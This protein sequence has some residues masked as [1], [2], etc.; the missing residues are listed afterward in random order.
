MK[1]NKYLL[2][3]ITIAL[4]VFPVLLFAQEDTYPPGTIQMTPKVDLNL[5]SV[6][7]I[8]PEKFQDYGTGGS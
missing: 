3:V 5:E 7:L 8:V 2:F 1:E 4:L 6:P